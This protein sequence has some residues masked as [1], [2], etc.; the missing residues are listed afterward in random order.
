M[1]ED[2]RRGR[3]GK[4]LLVFSAVV[5]FVAGLL[6]L[7]APV[8]RDNSMLNGDHCR[9]AETGRIMRA[10]SPNLILLAG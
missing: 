6:L 2:W 8:G 1:G 4:A 9:G 10:H 5:L 7:L 3:I